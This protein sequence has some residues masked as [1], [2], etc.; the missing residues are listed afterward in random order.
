MAEALL[1][2]ASEKLLALIQNEFATISGVKERAERLSSTMELIKAVLEDAEEKQITS[3]AVKVWLQQL[4]NAAYV[5][6][7]ILDECSI[8]YHQLGGLSSFKLKN[9]KLRHE[10]GTKLKDITRR[11]DQIAEDK[12]NHGLCEGVRRRPSEVDEWRQ[13]S[14]TV[15]QPRVYGRDDD[16]KKIVEFLL[17]QAPGSDSLSVYPIVGLGGLG[18]TTLAQFVYNDKAVSSHFDKRIWIWVSENFDRKRILCSI[19]EHITEKKYQVMDLDVMEREVQKL[20]QSTRYLLVLDDVWIANKELEFGLTQEKWNKLKSVLSCGSKGASILV[21]TRDKEVAAIMGTCKARH[22]SVLSDDDCWSLFNQYAF[23]PDKEER[24]ELVAIGKEIVKKCGGLPLAAQ[25][26]GGLMRSKSE[27]NE[28]LEIKES[29]LWALSDENSILPALM[30]SYLHLTPILKQCFSFCAIFPKDREIL[31]EEL[32]HLWMANGFISSR[33]NLEVEDVGN[34]IW[35]EL[36]QKSFFQDVQMDDASG[37]ILFKMHDL[38]HDLAKS[39][40]GQECLILENSNM[41]DLS[42]STHHISFGSS[43]SSFSEG[44]LQRVESLRTLY[45]FEFPL[46]YKISGYFPINSS[47]RV[48]RTSFFELSSLGILIHLRYLELRHLEKETLPDLICSLQKLEILKL[49]ACCKLKFL[50]KQ[51]SCLKNLRHF[52]IEGCSD[53][54]HMFPKIGKL[55][56]LKTLSMYIVSSEE[57]HSLGELQHLKLGGKLSIKGLENVSSLCE[58]E[59]ANL[60]GKKDLK[61]LCLSWGNNGET[62]SH[63]TNVEQVLEVLRPHSNLKKLEINSYEGLNLQSW[64]GILNGLVALRLFNCKNCTHLSSLG[65]LPFLRKLELKKMDNV[66]YLLNDECYNE[67]EVT[68]FPSLEYLKILRLPKLERLLKVERGNVC[69]RLS[70]LYISNCPKLELPYLPSV[71]RLICNGCND[72]FLS[73][74]SSFNTLTVLELTAD[75][76]TTITSFP[77]GMLRNLTCLKALRIYN[78]QKVKEFPNE[79]IYLKALDDLRIYL[80]EIECLPEHVWEGLCSLRTLQIRSCEGLRSLPEGFQ[81]LISLQLLLIVGCPALSERCKEGTGEDW[82]KIKHV[83]KLVLDGDPGILNYIW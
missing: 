4:K 82:H 64:M 11:F 37:R 65:K 14:S 38:V 28:W 72:M 10:I 42:K 53:L 15:D 18:K 47:L 77:E 46:D 2:F 78:F 34:I 43:L 60:V 48:L 35:K 32:I 41:T 21:S 20:L 9:I 39:V 61:E 70:D 23:G 59:G 50:P 26:L 51:M 69:L 54:T 74:I 80:P 31:K 45:Q 83:P 27:E 55:S 33:P 57:G 24:E 19:I 52:V 6:D 17:S 22:L 25:A 12:K 16:K 73:S 36:Y 49:I 13:T 7:D 1:G 40:M 66:Q 5:L 68:V 79:I 58:T 30:L 3:H 8:K 67:V 71:K 56:C 44:A 62:T 29:G 75:R 76:N 63:G 81:N